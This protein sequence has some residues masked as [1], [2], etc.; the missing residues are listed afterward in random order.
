MTN[1]LNQKVKDLK[2][3]RKTVLEFYP[4]D[5]CTLKNNKYV[6]TNENSIEEIT[7]SLLAK[8][9]PVLLKIEESFEYFINNEYLSHS[10]YIELIKINSKKLKGSLSKILSI[11]HN[12]AIDSELDILLN[13]VCKENKLT[14]TISTEFFTWEQHPDLLVEV[15][16]R[17]INLIPLKSKHQQ[18]IKK[19]LQ[20]MSIYG[21]VCPDIGD[22]EDSC[23]IIISEQ[24]IDCE[25]INNI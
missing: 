12:Y 21:F 10:A 23:S 4:R 14:S 1:N 6:V 15:T 13:N 11:K 7:R 2:K 25:D 18:A 17:D 20:T 3:E 24:R 19:V 5:F 8:F 22:I 16:T 9:S